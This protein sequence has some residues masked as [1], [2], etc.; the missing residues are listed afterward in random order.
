M[1]KK[2]VP[3]TVEDSVVLAELRRLACL[4]EELAADQQR[5]RRSLEV[6]I[7]QIGVVQIIL[8]HVWSRRPAGDDREQREWQQVLDCLSG[9]LT[10]ICIVLGRTMSRGQVPCLAVAMAH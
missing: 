6:A 8:R 7:A 2:D 10:E 5:S 9:A 4:V 1:T 3:A